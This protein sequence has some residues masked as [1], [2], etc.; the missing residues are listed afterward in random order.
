MLLFL[1]YVARLCCV[2]EIRL[3]HWV[4][5]RT[6]KFAKFLVTSSYFWISMF[7][8]V[9]KVL[10]QSN[11]G[12]WSNAQYKYESPAM[13]KQFDSKYFNVEAI[14][15]VHRQKKKS[16]TWTKEKWNATT[17]RDKFLPKITRCMSFTASEIFSCALCVEKQCWEAKKRST[18]RNTTQKLTAFN[19]DRKLREARKRIT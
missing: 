5:A 18:S 6:R 7:P 9:S 8:A 12:E 17:V 10:D 16:Q 15:V 3:G 13:T 11:L 1:E 19:V 14:T 2:N 4:L